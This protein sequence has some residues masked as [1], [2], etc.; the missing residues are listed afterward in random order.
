MLQVEIRQN[1]YKRCHQK[2]TEGNTGSFTNV[3]AKWHAH[4]ATA[5]TAINK[6]NNYL[7]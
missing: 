4:E 7:R 5:V 2:L 6:C 1:K 3:N